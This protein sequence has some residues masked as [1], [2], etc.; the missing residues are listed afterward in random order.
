[1]DKGTMAEEW[2]DP[3]HTA[4][5]FPEI[6]NDDDNEMEFDPLI[7]PEENQ[8]DKDGWFGSIE[9]Y[10][11]RNATFDNL[12]VCCKGKIGHPGKR[13]CRTQTRTW[14]VQVYRVW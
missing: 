6:R 5:F 11:K 8:M 10:N 2:F 4:D 9:Q 13:K 12:P 7:D 1:M 14:S 3:D